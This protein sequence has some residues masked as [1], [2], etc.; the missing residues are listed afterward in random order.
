M[1]ILANRA[2]TSMA[3]VVELCSENDGKGLSASFLPAAVMRDLLSRKAE[4]RN[5]TARCEVRQNSYE[6]ECYHI[7][8]PGSSPESTKGADS[9]SFRRQRLAVGGWFEVFCVNL[10]R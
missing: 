10:R 2:T 9:S 8:L 7:H 3:D 5:R 6:P 4:N 1:A